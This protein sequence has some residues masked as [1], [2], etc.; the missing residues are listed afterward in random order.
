MNSYEVTTLLTCYVI[1]LQ[2][3]IFKIFDIAEI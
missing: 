3:I 2:L 1:E